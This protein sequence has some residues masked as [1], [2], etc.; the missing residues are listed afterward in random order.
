MKKDIY[1]DTTNSCVN[2]GILRHIQRHNKF[3]CEWRHSSEGRIYVMASEKFNGSALIHRSASRTTML[4]VKFLKTKQGSLSFH[5]FIWLCPELSPA[6][7][8]VNAGLA[9]ESREKNCWWIDVKGPDGHSHGR[10][11][12]MP[13]NSGLPT[14]WLAWRAR[15][16]IFICK[17]GDPLYHL[18][19]VG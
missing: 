7:Q 14:S 17:F 13:R 2:E 8:V 16:K 19:Q 1:R 6:N 15:V 5:T 18:S 11:D 9:S 4:W 12:H 10:L 3:L